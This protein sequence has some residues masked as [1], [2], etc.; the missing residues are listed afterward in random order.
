MRDGKEHRYSMLHFQTLRFIQERERPLMQD[1]ARYLC[2]TPPAAT[3]LA[4]GLVKE[5][6]VRRSFDTKDRR[7]VRLTLTKE[8]K[9]F[10]ARGIRMRM[11]K[12]QELFAVLAPRER[13]ALISILKKI[14]QG[15]G[16]RS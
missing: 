1:I 13:T 4:E 9:S 6:L 11:K 5:G 10:L 16:D 2:I 7:T 12:I 3:L 14:A 8:G 15:A